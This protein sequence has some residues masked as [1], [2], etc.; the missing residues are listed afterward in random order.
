MLNNTNFLITAHNIDFAILSSV[1]DLKRQK[2]LVH[3]KVGD[4]LSKLGDLQKEARKQLRQMGVNTTIL[5]TPMS[6]DEYYEVMKIK[7]RCDIRKNRR[8]R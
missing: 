1:D 2:V 7:K 4:D 5:P 8:G 6:V 3:A